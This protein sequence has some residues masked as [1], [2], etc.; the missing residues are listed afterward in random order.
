MTSLP[1]S[2]LQ[3]L[4]H[5]NRIYPELSAT[6]MA[7][8]AWP[9]PLQRA[10]K[11]C[12]VEGQA[13]CNGK[14]QQTVT[15]SFPVW[16]D[17]HS[18]RDACNGMEGRGGEGKGREGK[19]RCSANCCGGKGVPLDPAEFSGRGYEAEKLRQIFNPHSSLSST[20]HIVGI[21]RD[22]QW[23]NQT[24]LSLKLPSRLSPRSQRGRSAISMK[25]TRKP[26]SLWPRIVS[27][28]TMLLWIM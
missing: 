1:L 22:P 20:T 8:S 2:V 5:R 19:G 21:N 13:A 12:E 28:R 9:K 6:I 7:F 24:Q 17:Q 27:R 16:N 11:G 14:R 10:P 15:L 4:A 25:S 3:S 23:Q 18:A 26:S